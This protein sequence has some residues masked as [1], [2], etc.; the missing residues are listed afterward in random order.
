MKPKTGD[1]RTGQGLCA[2]CKGFFTDFETLETPTRYAIRESVYI[3]GT[4][5]VHRSCVSHAAALETLKV[6][7]QHVGRGRS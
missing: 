5:W 4:G 2:Y 1:T 3:E 7:E 6:L